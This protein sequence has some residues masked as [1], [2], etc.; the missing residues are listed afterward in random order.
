MERSSQLLCLLCGILL[1]VLVTGCSAGKARFGGSGSGGAGASSSGSGGEGACMLCSEGGAAPGGKIVITPANPQ[2]D[3][4][5]GNIPTQQFSATLEGQDV[6]AKVTWVFDHP[7]VGD[8]D[9][10]GMF[11]PTGSV[12]GVGELVAMYA[13]DTGKTQVTVTVKKTVSSPGDV[14]RLRYKS[15]LY[16][17]VQYFAGPPPP[18]AYV[19]PQQDWENIE[20][21]GQ[22]P[23]SDP[24]KVELSRKSGP[25]VYQPKVFELRIAQGF[26]YGSVYY[27]QLPD[28]CGEGNGKIL[29]IKPSSDQTD[30]FFQP[31]ACWGC[32][33]VSRNGKE[34]MASFDTGMPFPLQTINLASDPATFGPITQG[35]GLGGTFSAYNH[36]GTKIM[37]SD[38]SSYLKGADATFLHIVDAKT[39]GYVLQNAM[40]PGCGEGAWSPDGQKLGAVCGMSGGGWT[41]DSSTGN[42][43]V[44]DFDN[45]TNTIKGS[46]VIV[47][48]GGPGR[49]AYPSFSPDSKYL[50]FGRPTA[51]SRTTGSGTLWL[52]G[53]DGAMPAELLSAEQG[54]GKSFNPVFAPKSAGGYFWLVFISRRDYGNQL[55][56]ANRQQ[57]WVTAVDDPPAA[58]DPSHPSFYLRGQQNCG[59]SENAYY[60]LDPCKDYGAECTTG[61][62]CCDG[63]CLH[64]PVSGKYICGKAPDPGE[65]VLTGNGCDHN[66]DCCDK[67]E[68]LCI[69]GFCQKPAPK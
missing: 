55:V 43:V 4:V 51:G 31:G 42:L 19:L 47:P 67:P 56:G 58:G 30:E 40:G 62:E 5:D 29:R 2:L 59:K 68:V 20:L 52:V 14:F 17:Y 18:A 38:N 9:K 27:W 53:V 49:P 1:G 3:V 33:S 21:S 69:Q 63:Q 28:A 22:G 8:I 6:T 25:T 35:I 11:V 50:A 45:G 61:I 10:T 48:Q 57:L 24:L 26:V 41:F 39:G 32:H 60:A 66:E 7:A 34:M 12:A 65:C 23:L 37:F 16:E 44:A 54:D 46:A 36:D 64:D 15:K 13:K